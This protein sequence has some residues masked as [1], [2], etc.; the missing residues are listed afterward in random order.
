MNHEFYMQRCLDLAT[1][2]LG[3]VAPNPLVGSVIV[4]ENKVI[5]EGYHMKY[6]QSH[7]EVNA[8]NSVLNKDLLKNSTI[9]INLEPCAHFG[10]TPP[11]AD[12]II[13]HE[14][15]RVVIGCID[16]FAEVSG[17]GI[18]KLKA[19]NCQVELGI[20]EA[21]SKELNKRFF[22]FHNKKRPYVIL[23]WA[24]SIDGFMDIDRKNSEKGI[25]WISSGASKQLVHQWRSEESGILI[26]KNT[27]LTDDPELTV[28][29]IEG[30]SPTRFV[31]DQKNEIDLSLFKLGQTPP[32]TVKI[33]G[34][35]C[36]S[37]QSILDFLYLENT[38]SVII[39]GGQKT[40][41]TFIEAD[42]WD[43]ARVIAGE[44]HLVSGKR[45]PIIDKKLVEEITLDT[46]KISY[47]KNV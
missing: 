18:E 21:E 15:P 3:K 25:F 30:Y 35:Y 7:A 22:T 36:S 26:G 28:R 38:Q 2:G 43:E 9:Y 6:G 1:L 27:L 31:L 20:L 8:I 37:A 11:C 46:D 17:K 4:H 19:A 10:K 40:L 12:L 41:S 29:E 13:K 16:S 44:V 32:K 14:I 33:T 39:E 42:L 47:F 24:Q 5:G 23:K 45:A 34:K